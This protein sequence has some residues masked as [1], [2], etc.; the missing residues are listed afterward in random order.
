M[1][2]RLAWILW[3]SFLAAIPAVGVVFSYVDPVEVA[4][5]WGYTDVGRIAVYTLG[6]LFFWALGALSSSMTYLLQRSPF[7][8]NHCILKPQDRPEGCPKRQSEGCQH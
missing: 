3:P 6:F 1:N 5:L 4:W 7:D 8:I 2:Q